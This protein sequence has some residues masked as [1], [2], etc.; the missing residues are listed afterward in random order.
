MSPCSV[1]NIPA[2]RMY[3]SRIIK[4]TVCKPFSR[5]LETLLRGREELQSRNREREWRGVEGSGGEWSCFVRSFILD[6]Q[7]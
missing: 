3:S 7:K 4:R 1:V 6:S 2:R 5:D